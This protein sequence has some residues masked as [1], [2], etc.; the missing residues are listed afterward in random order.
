MCYFCMSVLLLFWICSISSLVYSMRTEN[1]V[2]VMCN[3]KWIMQDKKILNVDEVFSYC[4]LP[5]M[6]SALLFHFPWIAPQIFPCQCR[7]LI[8]NLQLISASSAQEF[9]VYLLVRI[10]PGQEHVISMAKQASAEIVKRAGIKIPDRMNFVWWPTYKRCPA[11]LDIL[12]NEQML[13]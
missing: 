13:P 11:C 2:S 1:I 8:T 4:R 5:W 12:L 9:T 6:C 10:V 3:G 7:I